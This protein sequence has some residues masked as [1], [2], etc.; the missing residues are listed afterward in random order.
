M[1]GTRDHR[2]RAQA[3]PYVGGRP[4]RWADSDWFFGRDAESEALRSLWRESRLIVVHGIAGVGKTS[5]VQAGVLPLIAEAAG[6]DLLP[7][8][9][10]SS[11]DRA[12][13]HAD[14]VKYC[15]PSVQALLE[16]WATADHGVPETSLDGLIA[17]YSR[18]RYGDR[19]PAGLF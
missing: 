7:F 2:G 1:S 8:V 12:G 9:R 17:K 15:Y 5:L 14:E 19:E 4:F 13:H 16:V 11:T 10:L 3:S 6:T 18:R